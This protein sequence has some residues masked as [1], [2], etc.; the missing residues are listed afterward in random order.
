MD[1]V[2]GVF[3][4]VVEGDFT[5]TSSRFDNPY[6]PPTNMNYAVLQSKSEHTHSTCPPQSQ[7][8]SIHDDIVAMA[9]VTVMSHTSEQQSTPPLPEAIRPATPFPPTNERPKERTGMSILEI[10]EPTVSKEDEPAGYKKRKFDTMEVE[11]AGVADM[12]S[13]TA[14]EEDK[15]AELESTT[16]GF[17]PERPIKKMRLR[18]AATAVAGIVV[19]TVSAV[20]ALAFLPD[21]FFQ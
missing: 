1:L 17:P 4:Q 12:L 7:Q 9:P 2:T 14:R 16:P 11:G 6:V 5:L 8:A 13:T 10:V 20:G 21:V 3:G 15:F 18:R 19:G